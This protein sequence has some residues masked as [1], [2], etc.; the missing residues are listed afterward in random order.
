LRASLAATLGIG[1]TE[2]TAVGHVADAGQLMPKQLSARLGITPG[3]VTGVADGWSRPECS[4]AKP[5]PPTCAA[6][7][8]APPRPV[9]TPGNGPEEQFD[10][11]SRKP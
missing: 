11:L 6:S 2:L 1:V 3:S 5:I 7:C 4:N 8:C 9:S 10:A